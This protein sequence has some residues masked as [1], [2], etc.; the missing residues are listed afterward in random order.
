MVLTPLITLCHEKS[1][2]DAGAAS[3]AQSPNK[4]DTQTQVTAAA[5]N[6]MTAA[7]IKCGRHMN[8]YRC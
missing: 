3:L 8:L 1:M 4:E 6:T 2:F 7:N 5:A